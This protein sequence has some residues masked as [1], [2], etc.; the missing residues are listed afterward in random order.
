MAGETVSKEIRDRVRATHSNP[1]FQLPSGVQRLTTKLAIDSFTKW[2]QNTARGHVPIL[3]VDEQKSPS[4]KE[5]LSEIHD[6]VIVPNF[7]SEHDRSQFELYQ[8]FLL[9]QQMSNANKRPQGQYHDPDNSRS[10][11]NGPDEGR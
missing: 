9:F 11:N 10:R 1:N 5:A 3:Y 8:Q 6:D 4:S 7:T 2:R